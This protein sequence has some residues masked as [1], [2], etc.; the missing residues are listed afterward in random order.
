MEARC[1]RRMSDRYDPSL[2]MIAKQR[3][4]FGLL[5]YCFW[6]GDRIHTVQRIRL[7]YSAKAC[8]QNSMGQIGAPLRIDVGYVRFIFILI[9]CLRFFFGCIFL[10]VVT[11]LSGLLRKGLGL[12]IGYSYLSFDVLLC[13]FNVKRPQYVRSHISQI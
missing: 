12:P 1:C 2:E 5:F 7:F 3:S 8:I 9:L 10:M 4:L 13:C 6:F 11:Q